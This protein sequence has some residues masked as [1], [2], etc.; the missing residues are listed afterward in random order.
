MQF[1][2]LMNAYEQQPSNN[3]TDEMVM[4]DAKQDEAS[5]VNYFNAIFPIM[6]S[7]GYGGTVIAFGYHILARIR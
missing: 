1:E 4:N 5:V 6:M 2:L 3:S 7:M